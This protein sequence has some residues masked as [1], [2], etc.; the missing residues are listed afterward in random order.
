MACPLFHPSAP[1]SHQ[2]LQ[3]E[4]LS[5]SPAGPNPYFPCDASPQHLSWIYL[6]SF[7][8]S[9]RTRSLGTSAFGTLGWAPHVVRDLQQLS[10]VGRDRW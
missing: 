1:S 2:G 8:R 10:L 6:S 3:L 7:I 9:F 4:S 5:Y